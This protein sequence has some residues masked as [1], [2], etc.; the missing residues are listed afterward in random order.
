MTE[1]TTE[2]TLKRSKRHRTNRNHISTKDLVESN[3]HFSA[4]AQE[5]NRKEKIK[6][7]KRNASRAYF[8]GTVRQDR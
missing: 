7:E 1:E 3:R 5:L 8:Q 6:S 2:G 4:Y